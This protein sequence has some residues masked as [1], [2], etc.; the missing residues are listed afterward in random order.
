[1]ADLVRQKDENHV[2]LYCNNA[3]I[4]GT[5]F[6]LRMKFCEMIP[7]LNDVPVIHDHATVVLSWEHARALLELLK[8]RIADYEAQN[9]IRA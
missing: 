5:F 4:T 3:S 1:M 6:D 2:A 8:N 7:N 9:T